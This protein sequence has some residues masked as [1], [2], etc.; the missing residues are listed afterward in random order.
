MV[1][2][3]LADEAG[4]VVAVNSTTIT[5]EGSVVLTPANNS[6]LDTWSP[7]TPVTYTVTVSMATD[8]VCVPTAVRLLEWGDRAHINGNPIMLKG[9]SHHN[10]FGGVGVVQPARLELFH[11]QSARAMGA[12]FMRNA[13]NGFRDDLYTILTEL[14]MMAWDESRV[15]AVEHAAS[16]H[17]MVKQHRGHA[18]V[19]IW[20]YCNEISCSMTDVERAGPVYRAIAKGLDPDRATSGN[21]ILA[22]GACTSPLLKFVDVVGT[23]YGPVE[24]PP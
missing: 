6:T 14:G 3:S 10:S 15:F 7:H 24:N 22:K 9:F 21:M 4:V 1:T 18:S 13:H 5:H 17:D 12:N 19:S 23:S 16:F 2:F 8:E 20:S 11:V